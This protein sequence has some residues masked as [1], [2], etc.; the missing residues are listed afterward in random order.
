MDAAVFCLA[1][2]GG[3][4]SKE[5]WSDWT[6]A[7]RSHACPPGLDENAVLVTRTGRTR[8]RFLK[9]CVEVST[10]APTVR[11]HIRATTDYHVD[12]WGDETHWCILGETVRQPQ[13]YRDVVACSAEGHRHGPGEAEQ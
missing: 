11:I 1:Y 8:L 4:R 7:L 3:S 13:S 12:C 10:S 6:K 2:N 5:R 9:P